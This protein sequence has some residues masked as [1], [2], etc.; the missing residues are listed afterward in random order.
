MFA[1]FLYFYLM[2]CVVFGLGK[3]L[4]GMSVFLLFILEHSR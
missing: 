2:D 1:I 3:V 4:V